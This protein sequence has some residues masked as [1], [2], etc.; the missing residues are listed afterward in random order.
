EYCGMPSVE[1]L[2]VLAW[3]EQLRSVCAVEYEDDVLR[4]MRIQ[5]DL[6]SL[7]LPVRFVK[8]NILEFLSETDDCFD[9]YNLDFYGG[10]INPKKGG[11]AKCTVALKKLIE[12][13]SAKSRS[14]VLVTTFNVRDTGAQE[15]LGFIDKIPKALKGYKGVESSCRAHLKNQA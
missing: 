1:F 4:D 15:Y 12:R 9:V 3:E 10:F 13:Q 8:A 5:R 7:E 11:G 2:D 6:I 14:F